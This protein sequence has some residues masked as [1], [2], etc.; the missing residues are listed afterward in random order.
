MFVFLVVNIHH[1]SEEDHSPI[2]EKIVKSK[3]VHV[4]RLRPSNSKP[5][6]K[7]ADKG[8]LLI[9]ENHLLENG[10]NDALCENLKH[11]NNIFRAPMQQSQEPIWKILALILNRIFL[12]FHMVATTAIL[13]YFYF[14]F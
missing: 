8:S 3:I 10:A 4:L 14:K 9:L 2:I 11:F 13:L 6:S 12:F 5:K 7:I 1:F